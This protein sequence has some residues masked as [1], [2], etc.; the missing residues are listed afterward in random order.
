MLFSLDPRSP[1]TGSALLNDVQRTLHLKQGDILFREG[2]SG[3]YAFLVRRGELD[4]TVQ[5][6]AVRFLLNIIGAGELVGEMALLD[7]GP[8]TATVTARSDCEITAIPRRVFEQRLADADPV[9]AHC[10]RQ[11]LQ[12]YR[13]NLAAAAYLT[14][15]DPDQGITPSAESRQALAQVE[16]EALLRNALA[17]DELAVVYQPVLAL[18]SGRPIALEALVRWRPRGAEEDE[19]GG[20]LPAAT[21]SGLFDRLTGFVLDAALADLPALQDRL[22]DR[23]LPVS[24]NLA[25]PDLAAPGFVAGLRRSLDRA[26]LA[27]R[28]LVL[29]VTGQ[30]L[31][32][33][34]ERAA[35]TLRE[36]R[37][38]G[39]TVALDDFGSPRTGL[40]LLGEAAFDQLK[41]DAALIA[42]LPGD[43][44]CDLLVRQI[45]E[46]ADRFA[47]TAIAEG[48]AEAAQADALRAMGCPAGQGFHLGRPVRPGEIA[49]RHRA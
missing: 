14:P 37:E 5:R 15:P 9:L 32:E 26:G 38:A 27:P 42:P 31:R 21:Y 28:H 49:A 3:E 6:G 1:Q 8:R 24:L 23:D 12:H 7:S 18:K 30:R 44:R 19:A 46:L 4:V 33:A 36:A 16:I 17:N 20:F 45:L 43:A 25:A 35:A 29:E 10:T 40:D 41:I 39:I 2:S 47:M 48:V 34:G 13:S 11:M 22:G